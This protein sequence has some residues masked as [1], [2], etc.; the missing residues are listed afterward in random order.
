MSQATRLRRQEQR[1]AETRKQAVARWSPPELGSI[2]TLGLA[3]LGRTALRDSI[4]G[5]RERPVRP[6]VALWSSDPSAATIVV[7]RSRSSH[8]AVRFPEAH[9]ENVVP[10]YFVRKSAPRPSARPPRCILRDLPSVDWCARFLEPLH[11]EIRG[12]W[13]FPLSPSSRAY[14]G[15]RDRV[16]SGTPAI[17]P[18]RMSSAVRVFRP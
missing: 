7:E 9:L 2:L 15:H 5:C 14:T 1:H 4:A 16:G 6:R 10:G 11:T 13:R 3:V 18:G 8:C 12:M 17:G